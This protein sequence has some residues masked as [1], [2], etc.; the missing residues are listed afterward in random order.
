MFLY[1]FPFLI[2]LEWQKGKRSLLHV[3]GTISGMVA[4]QMRGSWVY[5]IEELLCPWYQRLPML[6]PT[7]LWPFLWYQLQ[8][9][10]KFSREFWINSHSQCPTS[11]T[12]HGPAFFFFLVTQLLLGYEYLQTGLAQVKHMQDWNKQGFSNS[13]RRLIANWKWE[14]LDK[15]AFSSSFQWTI[16]SLRMFK[17]PTEI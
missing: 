11:S 9:Q 5:N 13:W 7:S 8:M 15:R 16:V 2:P 17:L 6:H 3:K 4:K 12:F 1:H 14:S 10:W